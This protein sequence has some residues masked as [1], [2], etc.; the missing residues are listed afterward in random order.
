MA[1][2]FVSV[3]NEGVALTDI[4]LAFNLYN[5]RGTYDRSWGLSALNL[6]AHTPFDIR[7]CEFSEGQILRM[8][9]ALSDDDPMSPRGRPWGYVAPVSL[10]VIRFGERLPEGSSRAVHYVP[11]GHDDRAAVDPFNQPEED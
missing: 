5:E 8:A 4:P 3:D 11:A 7:W 10:P 9:Q 6:W 1:D 2:P